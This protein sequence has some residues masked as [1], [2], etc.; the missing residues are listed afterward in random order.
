MSDDI[1][2]NP[3]AWPVCSE[4]NTAYVLRR[5]ILFTTGTKGKKSEINEGWAWQRDC[6]HKKAEAV[7]Q[8]AHVAKPRKKKR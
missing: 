1:T 3:Q 4:C 2:V 7:L 5:A 8:R 6:K